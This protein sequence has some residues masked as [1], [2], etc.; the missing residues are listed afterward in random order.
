V[1]LS[2]EGKVLAYTVT[3]V[4]PSQFADQTPYAV[5]VIEL[6]DGVR[7]M[8]QIAGCDFDQLAPGQ[9]VRLEFRRIQKNGDA[10]ILCYGYKC[11]PV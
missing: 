5:G 2:Q 10:G 8:S 4:G 3:R 7:I 1:T 11:V 9:R 6:D